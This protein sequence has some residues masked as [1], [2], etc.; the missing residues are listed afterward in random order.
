MVDRAVLVPRVMLV[1]RELPAETE[2]PALLVVMAR[3][4]SPAFLDETVLKERSVL[5]V[6]VGG[7]DLQARMVGQGAPVL[8]DG[9]EAPA[10]L[11]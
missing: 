9:L 5:L 10:L 4:A 11:G 8:M 7:L 3:V 6:L 2:D 1:V